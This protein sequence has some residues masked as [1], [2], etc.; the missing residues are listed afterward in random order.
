MGRFIRGGP[1]PTH[2]SWIADRPIPAAWWI[3]D[4]PHPAA[5][6]IADRPIPAA[7]WIIDRPHPAAWWI[8]DRPHPAAWW[9]ID[10][11]QGRCRSARRC[12]VFGNVDIEGNGATLLN[13]G[14]AGEW[15]PGSAACDGCYS[16]T[17][18]DDD[19]LVQE[20]EVG[21]PLTCSGAL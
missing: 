2:A 7:W 20:D 5:S 9:I 19:K 14:V 21:D 11:P 10:R 8:I 1:R 16:F 3:I 13:V 4:R 12:Q 17:D 18:E 15:K 6:W